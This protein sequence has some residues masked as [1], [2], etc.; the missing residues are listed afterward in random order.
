L[1][2]V[3]SKYP[4]RPVLVDEVLKYL[5]TRPAGLYVDGTVGSGG[6][7]EAIGEKIKAGG[8]LICLDRDAEAIRISRERLSHMGD[9]VN[10]FQANYAGLKEVLQNMG[11][12]KVQGILLD[13]GMSSY[14]L[15][16]SGRGFSF[17]RN[18]PLDMRMDINGEVTAS[19][20]INDL[21]Q[22]D[23]E[24][25]LR[26]YGEEKRAKAIAALV[27]R[28][29]KKKSVDTSLQLA[30]LITTIIPPSR[31]PGIKHPA[32]RTF[33]ALR[34]VVNRELAHLE[35]FLNQAPS[36]IQVGGRLVILSY[37]SLEDRR[38]KQTM[39]AWE[40]RC[41]CPPDF[42]VCRCE[43]RPLFK[44]L[45]KKAIKPGE[46]EIKTNPRARSARLRAAERI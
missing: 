44:R 6:H 35:A 30:N 19:R 46:K 1:K 22:K 25:I 8:R 7:S 34:I 10:L 33:Q 14:Q 28:E 45:F 32:T 12:E 43:K 9:R 16:G 23:L 2:G 17:T 39:M 38:V 27:V 18:E 4:H 26:D 15:E 5:I 36:F 40:K 24:K 13:L 3:T 29:R 41:Q 20:L 31:S 37:H 42:P 11:F 21:P